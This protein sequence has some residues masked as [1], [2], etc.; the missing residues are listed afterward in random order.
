MNTRASVVRPSFGVGAALLL[1]LAVPGA[2]RADQPITA[3]LESMSLEE[4]MDIRVY[5]ASRREQKTT[6]APASVTIVTAEQIRRYGWRT[7]SEVLRS[8]RGFYGSYDRNY[9]AVGV[10]GVLRPGDYNSRVLVLVNG[11]RIND[12]LYGQVGMGHDF[13]LD[14]DLVERMEVVRGPTSSL[15]GSNAF[16]AVVNVI[17]RHGGALNG[18]EASGA[19]A[20]AGTYQGRATFGSGETSGRQVLLSASG[21][22]S[23]G[24]DLSFPEFAATHGGIATGMDGEGQAS[25]YGSASLGDFVLSGVY[26]HR[27][28][29]VPTA[30]YGT[31]FN[32]PRFKTWD[33]R[34]WLDLSWTKALGERTEV[35]AR[36]F[37]DWYR[38]TGDYPYA[39]VDETVIP[40]RDYTYINKDGAETQWFGAEFLLSHRLGDSN[41][42]SAGGEYRHAFQLDQW[43]YDEDPYLQALDDRR[44]EHAWALFLQDEVTL[45]GGV[46]LTAGLRYDHSSSFG[47]TTNPRLAVVWAA[48]SG[49]TLKLLY[50]SAFR[51]PNVYE[52]FYDDAGVSQVGNPALLPETIQTYEAVLEQ[53][54]GDKVRFTLTGFQN[55][56]FN[57]ITQVPVD[58]S[59]PSSLV[60]FRNSG[61]SRATG[62]EAEL[63]GK[64]RSVEARLSYAWQDATDR[65]TGAWLVNSPRHL[66]KAQLSSAFWGDRL[67]PALDLQYTGPRRTLAGSLAGD[68]WLAGF[69]L[70]A[71]RLLPGLEVAASVWNLFDTAYADPGTDTNTQDTIPQDGRSFRLAVTASF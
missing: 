15:F 29:E 3:Q 31:I 6:E 32:D 47:G 50:G 16:F 24:M 2:G 49:T 53:S 20:S 34:A 19:A 48:R 1:L 54:L 61:D 68:S 33:D 64:W 56:I 36:A 65:S 30:S 45:G 70:S 60:I 44:T 17:T 4:L 5:A 67:V 40:P 58:P 66:L 59:D 43:N 69:T 14:M 35:S 63:E 62:V 41:R 52:M 13:P 10:R 9:T 23:Q 38:Y 27:V 55:R 51:A 7:L 37:Y 12:M 28:K 11:H 39:G 42:L 8:V 46:T 26:G 18:V 57:L 22:T 21:Y 25:A 71:R